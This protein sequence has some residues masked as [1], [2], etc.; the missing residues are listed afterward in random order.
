MIVCDQTSRECMIHRREICPGLAPLREYLVNELCDAFDEEE[1]QTI[2]FKQWTNT[3]R[4]ELLTRTE[5]V[6]DFIELLIN[7]IDILTTHS[8]IAK[9]Q[10][11]Y[12]KKLKKRFKRK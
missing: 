8:Y 3:D 11:G 12:L 4:S 10:A 6:M 7:K 2:S 5:P 9:S 1:E